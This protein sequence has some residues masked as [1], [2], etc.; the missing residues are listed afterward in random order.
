MLAVN[1]SGQ[2]VTRG[3]L[4][5]VKFRVAGFSVRINL[6]RPNRACTRR[7]RKA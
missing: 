6:N 3:T 7:I 2:R 5:I 1:N 4:I